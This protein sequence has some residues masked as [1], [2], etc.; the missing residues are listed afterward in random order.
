MTRKIFG[1]IPI[2]LEDLNVIVLK[3]K[4]QTDADGDRIEVQSSKDYRVW[5]NCVLTLMRYLKANHPGY[6]DVHCQTPIFRGFL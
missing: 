5:R 4:Q 1:T 6:A 2:V 3:P